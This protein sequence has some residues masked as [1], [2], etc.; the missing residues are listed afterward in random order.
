MGALSGT[1][2]TSPSPTRTLCWTVFTGPDSS[3]PHLKPPLR[4]GKPWPRPCSQGGFSPCCFLSPSW[5]LEGPQDSSPA[6]MAISS[7]FW[8]IVGSV[9]MNRTEEPKMREKVARPVVSQLS[10]Y[11]LH[12]CE[13]LCEWGAQSGQGTVC[14]V[15]RPLATGHRAWPRLCLAVDGGG[16]HR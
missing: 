15:D 16:E 13:Q 5:L 9:S 1:A 7:V 10:L 8:S 3:N 11:L 6:M 14:C 4:E 12:T 2:L